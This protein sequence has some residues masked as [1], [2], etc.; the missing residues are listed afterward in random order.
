MKR[1]YAILAPGQFAD[2]AKT[3]H[4]VIAYGSSHH[5]VIEA[6]AI[7]AEDGLTTDYLRLRALP[8]T[9]AVA[10]FVGDHDRVYVVEQNRDGQFKTLLVNEA[11]V[12]P[13][14]LIPVLHYDGT[15]ITAR[16]ITGEIAKQVARLNVFPIRKTAS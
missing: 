6:R 9:Q 11:G 15:P 10:E 14:S 1:R 7:L 4:G 5:A 13:A 8:T 3:A 2:N 16:F 12:D